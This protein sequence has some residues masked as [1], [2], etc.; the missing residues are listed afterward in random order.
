MAE[1]EA[2]EA[3]GGSSTVTHTPLHRR[4]AEN[5]SNRIV[6]G[7]LMPG[8]KL[9]SERQIAHQFTASRATVRTALQHLEQ[10][11][12]ITRRDRRSAVVATRRDVRPNLR[13]AF[14]SPCLVNLFRNLSEKQVLPTRS[15]LQLLDM[16]MH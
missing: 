14:S 7:E 11:G 9:P 5:L 13:M 10:E 2:F 15:Q 16:I 4:I 12:L 3:Q 1:N 6:G 8:K